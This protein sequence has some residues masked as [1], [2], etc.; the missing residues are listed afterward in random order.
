MPIKYI[1]CPAGMHRAIEWCLADCRDRCITQS[2]ARAVTEERVW[3]GV[4]S[5]TQ[6][7]NG[8]M[9]EFLKLT[10]DYAIDPQKRAFSVLG[11]HHH[12]HLEVFGVMAEVKVGNEITSTVDLLEPDPTEPG[13]YILTDY[14][15][16]GSY[17]VARVLGLVRE[18]KGKEAVF[19][20]AKP[21][22]S[23]WESELQLNHYR[24]QAT[25]AGLPVSKMQVQCTVRDGGL[26]IA[27]TRGIDRNIYIIPIQKLDDSSIDDYFKRKAGCLQ[28]ALKQ[29][30]WNEPCNDEESWEGR[31]CK[32]YC[33][34]AEWCL[35]GKLLIAGAV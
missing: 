8:T 2:T 17:A 9:L 16:W 28:L 11:T 14:K 33:E 1:I 4:P 3:S 25:R 32:D 12:Q 31:R 21:H 20:Y 10:K 30:W 22:P 19:V 29:G 34:V 26:A 27:A 23:D 7:I 18:G 6:L 24:L 35:K 5:T 15:T 13:S